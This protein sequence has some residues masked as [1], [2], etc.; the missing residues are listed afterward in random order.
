MYTSKIICTLQE[1]QKVIYVNKFIA[2]VKK[3]I[4]DMKA[5]P[6]HLTNN[7]PAGN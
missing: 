6:M 4:G 2:K 5:H 7:V 3:I 1:N